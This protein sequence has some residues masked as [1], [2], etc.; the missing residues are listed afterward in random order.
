MKK[1][2][3]NRLK[4]IR[5]QKVDIAK[6]SDKTLLM[7]LYFTQLLTL[8]IALGIMWA[9]ARNPLALL[10]LPSGA[11]PWIWGA[12]F[13]GAVLAV[14]ALISRWIPEDVTDDGGINDKLFGNRSILQ[15]VL[16]SFIVAVCEEML[17]RGAVQHMIGPYWTSILFASMH[18]R[19]LR[20]WLMTGLV[21]S[22][23]YGL[24]WIAIQSGTLWTP[25]AAHFIIDM[26]MGL[27]IRFRRRAES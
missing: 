19:Y 26:V 22:I 10:S 17:F 15:I 6:V 20:H 2:D 1:F 21:F 9:Q 5:L 18:F 3:F 16:I 7:N 27:I 23:S 12:G 24:G 13:A 4:N 11:M 25:I 14:D 8:L